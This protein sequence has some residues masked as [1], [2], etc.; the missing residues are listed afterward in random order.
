MAVFMTVL[1]IEI[2][3]GCGLLASGGR[4]MICVLMCG[5]HRAAWVAAMELGPKR[6]VLG[7]GDH[8]IGQ[9]YH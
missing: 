7:V 9:Y 2:D 1:S 6:Q 8:M 3:G 5:R 4:V